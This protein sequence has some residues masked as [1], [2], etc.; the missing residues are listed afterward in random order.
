MSDERTES[1]GRA[2]WLALME[3]TA[4]VKERNEAVELIERGA[5]EEGER[6]FVRLARAG[7]PR[8]AIQV[9]RWAIE[10]GEFADWCELIPAALKSL[11]NDPPELIEVLCDLSEAENQCRDVVQRAV[12]EAGAW[13]AAAEKSAEGGPVTLGTVRAARQ[14]IAPFMRRRGF[15]KRVR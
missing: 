15:L 8:A 12:A 5:V 2:A 3:Q 9:L 6:E 14:R 13:L 4:R 11:P 10:R 1:M 7:E